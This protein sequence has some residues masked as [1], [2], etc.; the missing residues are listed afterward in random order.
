[1]PTDSPVVGYT[2]QDTALEFGPPSSTGKL[3]PLLLE[4]ALLA[5]LVVPQQADGIFPHLTHGHT[6]FTARI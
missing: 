6:C 3:I 1:M 2:A 4:G 5:A